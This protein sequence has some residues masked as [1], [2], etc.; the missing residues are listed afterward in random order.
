MHVNAE[1]F[2]AAGKAGIDAFN[3]LARS[4]VDTFELISALNFGAGKIALE[5]GFSHVSALMC[6][7]AAHELMQRGAAATYP[8]FGHAIAY[9]RGLHSVAAQTRAEFLKLSASRAVETNRAAID[10]LERLGK[11][12]PAGS[13]V[14]LHA[15]TSALAAINAVQESLAPTATN[16]FAA[17]EA[18]VV[19]EPKRTAQKKRR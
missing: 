10:I 6:A 11:S 5:V 4:Q 1:P 14:T 16:K 7:K 3:T 8:I 15:I 12:A 13:G 9:S 2:I 19:T 18:P 17:A